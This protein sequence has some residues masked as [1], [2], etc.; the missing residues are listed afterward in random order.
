MAGRQE[1][2]KVGITAGYMSELADKEL[3]EKI[4]EAAI[5]F[6]K[7]LGPGYVEAFYEKALCIELEL[8]GVVYE[9]QKPVEVHY[10]NQLIGQHRLDLLIES[11]VVVEL[12]AVK[13]IEPVFF[14][15]VRSYM[16]A[17]DLESGIILNF[18]SMPLTIKRVG[19]ERVS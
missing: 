12:K 18:A 5:T 2:R 15:I 6:H 3:T 7:Q 8:A 4:I 11:R 9:V 1:L 14:S 13:E 17:L 16:K 10:R 19:R